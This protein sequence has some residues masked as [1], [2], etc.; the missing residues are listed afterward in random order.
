MSVET[1]PAAPSSPGQTDAQPAD[2]QARPQSGAAASSERCKR[3]HRG[4]S[5]IE[6]RGRHDHGR[7]DN[8]D[9]ILRDR[10]DD[11]SLK[12]RE[13]GEQG[14]AE[15][16]TWE[17]WRSNIQVESYLWARKLPGNWQ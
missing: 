1:L 11:E 3:S 14:L 2:R 16:A 12:E 17:P 13:P 5:G 4:S 9:L 10:C 7:P 15:T 8:H 6:I